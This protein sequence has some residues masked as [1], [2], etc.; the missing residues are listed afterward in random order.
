MS[1]PAI[2]PAE[3]RGKALQPVTVLKSIFK[4]QARSK[5]QSWP[6]PLMGCAPCF[7]S[8]L[9]EPGS[10]L[11]PVMLHPGV[12]LGCSQDR[13]QNEELSDSPVSHSWSIGCGSV[14]KFRT[15][16]QL[17]AAF[18]VNELPVS[19][20]IFNGRCPETGRHNVFSQWQRYPLAG[21]L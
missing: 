14:L 11:L 5:S 21:R 18:L 19:L 3:H 15:C 8:K 7:C 6:E 2:Q 4:W 10:R 16:W 20:R 1:I 13:T 17:S 9:A 12:G